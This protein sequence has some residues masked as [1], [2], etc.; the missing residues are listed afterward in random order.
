M[1][2]PLDA[3][4][5]LEKLTGY[6]LVFKEVD[7]KSKFL[8]QAGFTPDNPDELER[9][10]RAQAAEY[11]A[12]QDWS[13]RFGDYFQV[14]GDLRGVNGRILSVIAIWLKD[15]ESGRYRFITLKPWRKL[16]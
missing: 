3:E 7:D 2:I 12:V 5:A 6:L 15:R 4:I 11:E 1:K 13:N 16:E 14:R 9:A 10:I 8:A